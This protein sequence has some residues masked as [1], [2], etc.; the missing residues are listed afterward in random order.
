MM[1]YRIE[2]DTLPVVI[3][4]LDY[5]ETMINEGGSMSWMSPAV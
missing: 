2:G 5:G 1:K 4:E 3:C